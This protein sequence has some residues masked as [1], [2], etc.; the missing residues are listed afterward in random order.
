[1]DFFCRW[2]AL[3]LLA[4]IPERVT[5]HLVLKFRRREEGSVHWELLLP[6]TTASIILACMAIVF[7]GHSSGAKTKILFTCVFPKTITTPGIEEILCYLFLIDCELTLC[8]TVRSLQ[9]RDKLSHMKN[10]SLFEQ[11]SIWLGQH[12]TGNGRST[13]TAGARK[14]LCWLK[15]KKNCTTL[16]L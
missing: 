9:L 15:K 3:S 7:P 12:Q 13:P 6:L 5:L 8:S 14:S 16:D 4:F 10:F 11:K 2:Q 1:M